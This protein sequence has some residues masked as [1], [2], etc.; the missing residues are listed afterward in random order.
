[1]APGRRTASPLHPV[2]AAACV[3]PPNVAARPAY[4]PV[5]AVREPPLQRPSMSWSKRS[6]A[7]RRPTHGSKGTAPPW[8]YTTRKR[9]WFRRSCSQSAGKRRN[10]GHARQ[11]AQLRGGHCHRKQP[12]GKSGPEKIH[13]PR[14]NARTSPPATPR[15]RTSRQGSTT[16]PDGKEANCEHTTLG[17]REFLCVSRNFSS[18]NCSPAAKRHGRGEDSRRIPHRR[19]EGRKRGGCSKIHWT[20]RAGRQHDRDLHRSHRGGWFLAV[21][22]LG[23]GSAGRG[24][25]G[26]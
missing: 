5:G 10:F 9:P 25:K 2:R 8:P 7:G 20:D 11:F 16:H 13:K 18:R 24:V 23:A 1:M 15:P 4:P 12:A 22:G 14:G 19:R 6:D 26:A 21:A 3:G 17:A